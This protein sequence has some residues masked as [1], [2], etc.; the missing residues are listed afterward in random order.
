ML[1][2]VGAAA[3]AA[4]LGTLVP[5]VVTKVVTCFGTTSNDIKDVANM[6]KRLKKKRRSIEDTICIFNELANNGIEMS[7]HKR[8]K[9]HSRS[10]RHSRSRPSSRSS[11]RLRPRSRSR[12]RSRS[13]DRRPA[14]VHGTN[15]DRNDAQEQEHY[16]NVKTEKEERKEPKGRASKAKKLDYCIGYIKNTNLEEFVNDPEFTSK[17]ENSREAIKHHVDLIYAAKA[18]ENQ[19]RYRRNNLEQD[20]RTTVKRDFDVGRY[21]ENFPVLGEAQVLQ[22]TVAKTPM[23]STTSVTSE[24][25]SDKKI[26]KEKEKEKQTDVA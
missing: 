19:K 9:S 12:S 25:P 8:H 15:G 20:P 23:K 14:P 10:R 24:Q 3:A 18:I 16:D 22:N 13:K 11:S 1:A 5:P 2:L 21:Y 6:E 26:E 17:W 4:A 7:Q